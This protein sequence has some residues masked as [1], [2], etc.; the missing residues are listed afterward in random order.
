MFLK[1]WL[2]SKELILYSVSYFIKMLLQLAFA[3][4]E[5]ECQKKADLEMQEGT[6]A[7]LANNNRIKTTKLWACV[8]Q[9]KGETQNSCQSFIISFNF[10]DRD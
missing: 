9:W 3:R 6:W 4:R 10:N 7:L 2:I 5:I 8:N 1:Y